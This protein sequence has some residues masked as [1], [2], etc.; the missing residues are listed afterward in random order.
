RCAGR[1]VVAMAVRGRGGVYGAAR[2][3]RA[4]RE[5]G[6]RPIVGCELPM[7]DGSVVPVLAKSRQGYRNLCKL[8]TRAYLPAAKGEGRVAWEALPEFSEGLIALSGDAE[9]PLARAWAAGDKAGVA[10]AVERLTRGFGADN[11]YLEVQRHHE[12][13]EERWVAALRDLAAATG[14]PLVATNG[15]AYARPDG[16]ALQDVFTCLREKVNFDNAGA[17]LSRN[18]QR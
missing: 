7:A 1:G 5:Q 9:G 18:G 6:V 12:R 8:L 2:F 10:A 3:F 17:L 14:L 13:G 4:A 11:V 15:V 16:R